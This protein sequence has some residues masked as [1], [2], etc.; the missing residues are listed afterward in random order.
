MFATINTDDPIIVGVFVDA[1]DKKSLNGTQI[2]VSNENDKNLLVSHPVSISSYNLFIAINGNIYIDNGAFKHRF[3]QRSLDPI[4]QRD[5][6][7]QLHNCTSLF[8]DINDSIYCSYSQHHK[9]IQILLNKNSSKNIT[10]GNGNNGSRPDLLY[11][12][13]GLFVDTNLRLYVVDTGNHRVQRFEQGNINGITV[14]GNITLGDRG[15]R[16]PTAVVVDENGY[17]YILD[18]GN[19]RIIRSENNAFRL[20]IITGCWPYYHSL[21]VP[22]ALWFDTDGNMFV[23]NRAQRQIRKFSLVV[24][25]LGTFDSLKSKEE[26]MCFVLLKKVFSVRKNRFLDN[27]F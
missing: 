9:V 23:F 16:Y 4:F 13:G 27:T 24:G 2:V 20:I 18:C 6:M 25:L 11:W 5:V 10:Y 7:P 17:L 21:F 19:Q 14:A 22:A 15:L 26:T 1:T 12:P 3:Y 8:M